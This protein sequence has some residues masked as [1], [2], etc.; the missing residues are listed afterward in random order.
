MA[1]LNPPEI[2]PPLIRVIVEAAAMYGKPVDDEKLIELLSPGDAEDPGSIGRADKG[3][4]RHSHT[5]AR[6][7]GF[8]ESGDGGSSPSPAAMEQLKSGTLRAGWRGLLRRSVLEHASAPNAVPEASAESTTGAKDLIF[9]LTWFLA[10]DALAAPMGWDGGNGYRSFQALQQQQVGG[11]STKHPIQNDTRFGAFERWS[12]HL[13]LARADELGARAL[14][15][16]PTGAIREA[17]TGLP[18]GRHDINDFCHQLGDAVP[19]LWPG[20]MR[21][22]LIDVLGEDP[23]PD[24]AAGGIDSS[25]AAS[26]ATLEA[27]GLI[28]LDNL[29]DAKQRTTIAPRSPQPR[30]VTHVEVVE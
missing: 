3:H 6:E 7:L 19:C 20:P 9:A 11:V 16:L 24:V 17:M 12:L 27:E 8:M 13:G 21:Q 10:Q 26:L 14:R 25:I 15:P 28:R 5:A 30:N 29:A 4:V 2:L 22:Q 1:L 18:A 23:D